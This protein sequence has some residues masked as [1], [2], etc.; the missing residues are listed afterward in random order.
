MAKEVE[1]VTPTTVDK[2]YDLIRDKLMLGEFSSGQRVSQR[3]LAREFGCSTIPI[4]EAMRRL[5][6]EGLFVKEPLKIARV[7]KLS[8]KDLEGLYLVREGL[9]AVATRL[10]A[11]RITDEQLVD[12]Y[13]L[14]R[15]F[16]EAVQA[17]NA[18]TY[19]RYDVE[20]HR[21]IYKCADCPLL[22]TELERLMLLEKTAGREFSTLDLQAYIRGHRV[23]IQ[24][25]ADH[26][27]D[28]AEYL[29]RRH[30]R[31]GRKELTE[32]D[33]PRKAKRGA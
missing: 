28:A 18:D 3:K 13:G 5:E 12:L 27:A 21:F 20:I 1:E 29:A 17:G 23:L 33:S 10:C 22:R 24:A 11:E 15:R 16:E 7:R 32:K 19:N 26:D 8:R 9:E 25:I 31:K 14:C 30:I 4:A 2:V 6:S